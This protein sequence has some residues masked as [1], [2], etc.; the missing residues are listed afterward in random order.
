MT[1]PR[2][3]PLGD[4]AL[5]LVFGE[6]IDPVLH[7]RILGVTR[8]LRA[9]PPRGVLEIVPAYATIGVWFDPLA[10]DPADLTAELLARAGDPRLDDQSPTG[11]EWRIPVRYDGPDLRDVAERV[12]LRP[13]EV[14]ALHTAR[15]YHVFLLGFVPG[16][17]FLG[18]LDPELVLPRR[19]SPRTLVPAG[20]VAIAGVQTGI[21]PLDTP[22]GWHLIG[23]TDVR[24]W[25]PSRN[26]PALFAVGDTVR[27][28]A[29]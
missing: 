27:F 23:R 21:Y 25:D 22:G 3:L 19:A 12:S 20:S 9:D 10:R 18:T 24:L 8:H 14:V 1:A 11:R 13:A 29:A 26:P 4:S 16:F 2:C 17:A 15:A 28:E 7:Q 5:T 6:V